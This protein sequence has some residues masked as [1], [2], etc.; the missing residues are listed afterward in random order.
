VT[1]FSAL[2]LAK[3]YVSAA[4]ITPSA[5]AN[6]LARMHGRML[7]LSPASSHAFGRATNHRIKKSGHLSAVTTS[8][9]PAV[10]QLR[11]AEAETHHWQR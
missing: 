2:P 9:H 3:I 7:C 1:T 6:L 5:A 8:S 11:R 10:E 4:S